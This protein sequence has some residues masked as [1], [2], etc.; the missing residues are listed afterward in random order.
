MHS[1]Y[2]Y[3]FASITTATI[4]MEAVLKHQCNIVSHYKRCHLDT[5]TCLS[6]FFWCRRLLGFDINQNL[7]LFLFNEINGVREL[8]DLYDDDDDDDAADDDE[9]DDNDLF[10][11]VGGRCTGCSELGC[12]GCRIIFLYGIMS[13]SN[14]FSYQ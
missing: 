3:V 1:L 6:F 11:G 14:N 12:K 10:D 4:T 8:S 9:D 13:T 2:L 7:F 5:T